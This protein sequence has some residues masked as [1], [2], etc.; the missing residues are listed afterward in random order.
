MIG[1]NYQIKRDFEVSCDSVVRKTDDKI[2]L[3]D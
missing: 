3:S 2:E 1:F